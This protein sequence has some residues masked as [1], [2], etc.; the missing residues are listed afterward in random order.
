MP[1]GK[2]SMSTEADAGGSREAELLAEN[3]RL[4]L[5]LD[6]AGLDEAGQRHRGSAPG[7]DRPFLAAFKHTRMPMVVTDPSLPDNPI[8]FVNAAFLV[9]TGYAEH[10]VRGRNCRFL[11]GPKT[12][13][14]AVA[15]IRRAIAAGEEITTDILNYRRD[16][17]IFWNELYISP[18]RDPDGRIRHFFASQVDVTRR[19]DAE[20]A[21]AELR[22]INE[23]LEQRVAEAV[24][25]RERALAHLA[26]SHK[27]EALGQLAGGVAHDFN[28]AL[29]TITGGARMILRRGDDNAAVQRFAG[30]VL[31]AANRGTSVTRRLLAFARRDALRA[32]PVDI[33][34]LLGGFQEVLAHTLGA[35]INIRVE[36]SGGL[37]FPWADRSQLETVLVNLATNA[38]D[39]MLPAGGTVTLSAAVE[40]VAD[41]STH[42]AG[43]TAGK[44]MRLTVADTGAGM[45]AETL[46]HATEPFFTTKPQGKGTGLGLSMARGFAEQ[47]GGKLW[48]ESAPGHG[49]AIMLWLPLMSDEVKEENVEALHPPTSNDNVPDPEVKLLLVDDDRLV[50]GTLA[51]ELRDRGYNVVEAEGGRAALQV[52]DACQRVDLLV[53]DLSMPGMDGASLIYE[54]QKRR[55]GLPAVLV[56]GYAGD[57][58]TLAVGEVAPDATFTLLRKPTS[59]TELGDL[60]AALLQRGCGG[61][62]GAD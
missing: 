17:S 20:R 9:L 19:Q 54:A 24:A 30:M 51:A 2:T 16:G 37:P 34:G 12:D 27:L 45:D 29:Q 59:A 41:P 48:V 57:G 14:D 56:T 58:A 46:A 26:Q 35:G 42:S 8:V 60:V 55:P 32:E 18:I 5:L 40:V 7:Y 49:T 11:Q 22:R 3:A 43:L 47:S 38:R 23:T 52:L 50:R 13:R 6:E 31:E 28:N 21:E 61:Q 25:E 53:T 36:I 10:E 4:R 15:R 44:Y 33:A 62:G 39:A 1:F